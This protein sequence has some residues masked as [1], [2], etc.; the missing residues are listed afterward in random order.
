[1]LLLWVFPQVLETLLRIKRHDPVIYKPE[2]AF[3]PDEEAQGEGEEEDEAAAA[4]VDD[5]SGARKRR[6][7]EKPLHLRTLL[8]QQ[9]RLTPNTHGTI[10]RRMRRKCSCLLLA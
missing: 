9:V 4:A 7:T 8:A 2:V 5:G 3:F 1:M 6:K 10:S